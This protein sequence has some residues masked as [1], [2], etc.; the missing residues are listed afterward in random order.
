VAWRVSNCTVPRRVFS[1]QITSQ[2]AYA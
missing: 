1:I 2:N